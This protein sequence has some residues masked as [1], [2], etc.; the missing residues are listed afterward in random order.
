MQ[1]HLLV[2]HFR[3][4]P[5]GA[6]SSSSGDHSLHCRRQHPSKAASE[7]PPPFQVYIQALERVDLRSQFAKDN[8]RT[9]ALD[10]NCHRFL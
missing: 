10:P 8:L 2:F 6:S 5:T 1:T 9:S 3:P 7:V 4:P